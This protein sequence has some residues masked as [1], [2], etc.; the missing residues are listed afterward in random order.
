MKM[1]QLLKNLGS[2][3]GDIVEDDSSTADLQ[4]RTQTPD[5]ELSRH[6][7]EV[8]TEAIESS[9]EEE[10]EDDKDTVEARVARC[11]EKQNQLDT[12]L[13]SLQQ[14]I[15]SLRAY[16]IGIHAAQQIQTAVISC[17][18]KLIRNRGQKTEDKILL[19]PDPTKDVNTSDGETTT[20]V[21]IG[22]NTSLTNIQGSGSSKF[23][24]AKVRK[25]SKA[26]ADQTFGQ[27]HAQLRH[28]QTQIDSEATESSSG[29][30][31]A[32]EFEKFPPGG[33]KYAP[34]RER[35]LYRW[36]Q[37]RSEYAAQWGW[38]QCQISDLEFRIR[39]Q[40]EMYRAYR[41]AK[42]AVTLAEDVVP[43]SPYKAGRYLGTAQ[44]P[45]G[46]K[47][48]PVEFDYTS[49]DTSEDESTLTCSRVRPVNRVKRRKL[50]DTYGLHHTSSRASKPSAY[51]CGC[52][53]PD[54]WC[55]L[56]LGRYSHKQ[57]VDIYTQSRQECLALLDHGYHAVLSRKSDIPLN[58]ALMEGIAKKKWVNVPTITRNPYT[59]SHI[60]KLL[61]INDRDKPSENRERVLNKRKAIRRKNVEE[62]VRKRLDLVKKGDKSRPSTPEMNTNTVVK[63]IKE[64]KEV[65]E[66][67]RI[68]DTNSLQEQA[69]RKRKNSFDIDH[70]VI[71][72]NMASS[73]VEKPKYKE[74][75]TPSWREVDKPYPW[76]PPGS[77]KKSL[78]KK[79]EPPKPKASSPDFEDISNLTMAILHAKAEEE[80]RI[81]WATP[82]G[83]V[84]GG[85]RQ[86][87][88]R[89]R[90]LD[91]CMTE[92]SSGANTPDPLS[93][94]II[95]RVEDIV[96]QTRPS[97][98]QEEGPLTPGSSLAI[99]GASATSSTATASAS[100]S[101]PPSYS[102]GSTPAAAAAAL[103]LN[104]PT[105]ASVKNRRRTSSQTKSRDRNLSEASQ[106]SQESSRS[107]SPWTEVV[108]MQ[109]YEPRQF[110]LT[111][112]EMKQIEIE[113]RMMR[114]N[115]PSV[116]SDLTTS[117]VTSRTTSRSSSV[118][119]DSAD[120]D[121]DGPSRSRPPGDKDELSAQEES[122]LIDED[123][124]YTPDMD[125][126]TD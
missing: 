76:P 91:S 94:G 54:E 75:Q 39:Q 7:D 4:L 56:C 84:H 43:P 19:K 88:N 34:I 23:R 96:V 115:L 63:E 24:R 59:P 1:D 93:P 113:D 85:Q 72:Y 124:E 10:V 26:K 79:P 45:D 123:P 103:N 106:H 120:P 47:R 12:R 2:S 41:E 108:E 74:I 29:G 5:H 11:R 32:D 83:R 48:R 37:K 20:A 100:A 89:V 50:I 62:R 61:D 31:S 16:K 53:H 112:D 46:I 49:E 78:A 104:V 18:K 51:S 86:R 67:A 110:P 13:T 65:K 25:L 15:N 81:R 57:K 69:R 107:T 121:W 119:E 102:S 44:G 126:S 90:R 28:V 92:A 38:L 99:P 101:Q 14:R 33:T 35:A 80:E 17:E 64:I 95:D 42:G 105:P 70:I 40:N 77:S 22:G 111:D 114:P 3:I 82:L 73:R 98:P 87:G 97:S 109:P 66:M 58:H 125:K 8:F 122:G 30:D 6:V 21:S 117:A 60:T 36:L 27:L 68:R 118:S 9:I 52:L 116:S 71:P 55:V